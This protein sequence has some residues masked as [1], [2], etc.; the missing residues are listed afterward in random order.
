[1]CF[2][3]GCI[4]VILMFGTWA[5]V[6]NHSTPRITADVPDISLVTSGGVLRGGKSGCSVQIEQPGVCAALGTSTRSIWAH[7]E[8]FEA[9]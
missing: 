6:E 4:P 9:T 5:E 2:V 1:M 7:G 8:L 3:V